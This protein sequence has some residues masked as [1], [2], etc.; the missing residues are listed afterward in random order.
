MRYA[1]VYDTN[2]LEK[3]YD[4]AAQIVR[5]YSTSVTLRQLF[6]RLVSAQVIPNTESAYK[7][8]S[9]RTAEARRQSKF[10]LLIDRGRSI[11]QPMYFESPAAAWETLADSY[12]RDR[13]VG[14]DVL[15]YVGVEKAGMVI[16][17]QSWFG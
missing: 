16:Q 5:S 7:T 2:Q 13:T 8:L 6:Y 1:I 4:N 3:R 12:R 17:L 14:Q 9:S 15:I 11:Y 10:P